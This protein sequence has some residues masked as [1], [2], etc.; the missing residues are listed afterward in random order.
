[1]HHILRLQAPFKL[2]DFDPHIHEQQYVTASPWIAILL[3]IVYPTYRQR[4]E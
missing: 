2:Y 1:M 3:A 4:I